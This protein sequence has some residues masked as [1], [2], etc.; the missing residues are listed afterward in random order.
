ML[1]NHRNF[2]NANGNVILLKDY[3]QIHSVSNVM[4]LC[5]QMAYSQPLYPDRIV[6]NPLFA[7]STITISGYFI[8]G[9]N[10]V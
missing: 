6:C 2:I 3:T 4:V 10:M 7:I 9:I 1:N 8:E 5:N